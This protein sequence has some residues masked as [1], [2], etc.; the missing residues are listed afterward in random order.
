MDIVGLNRSK[1]ACVL[2]LW[3]WDE[4][5]LRTCVQDFSAMSAGFSQWH[6]EKFP[7]KVSAVSREG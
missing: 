7:Y 6:R 3:R 1:Y 4:L 2:D 5:D